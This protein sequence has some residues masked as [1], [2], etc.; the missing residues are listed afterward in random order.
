[1]RSKKT[2]CWSEQSSSG[3][4]LFLCAHHGRWIGIGFWNWT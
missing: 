3:P 4:H 2:L 1:M